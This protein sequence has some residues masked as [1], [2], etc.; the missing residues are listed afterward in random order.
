MRRPTHPTTLWL[1]LALAC[2]APA[3]GQEGAQK[4]PAKA[5]PAEAAAKP[6]RPTRASQAAQRA[7]AKRLVEKRAAVE[8]L[9]SQLELEKAKVKD[10]LRSL[11]LQKA[12]LERRL[13]ALDVDLAEVQAAAKEHEDEIARKQALR[14]G[15]RPVALT[16]LAKLEA[17]VRAAIPFRQAERLGEL[18][19]LRADLEKDAVAPDEAL[20]RLWSTVEDE[21]RLTRENG[22]YRQTIELDGASHLAD[23]VKLGTALMYFRTPSGQLGLVRRQ[24]EAWRYVVVK[25]EPRQELVR[26]LFA[27]LDKHMRQGFFELPNPQSAPEV[28]K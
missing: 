10:E 7:L 28:T 26:A 23:V 6:Q 9:A 16:Q 12:D 24:G 2:A 3:L 25:D 21:L 11:S 18:A 5:A 27:A 13:K 1:G 20:S 14:E 4:A 15:L 19:K 17:Y 22:K 8:E